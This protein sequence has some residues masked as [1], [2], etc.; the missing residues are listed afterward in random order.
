MPKNLAPTRVGPCPSLHYPPP[1]RNVHLW[2]I[3]F[4]LPAMNG[5]LPAELKFKDNT[6][7]SI[8]V[9]IGGWKG[10]NNGLET[11]YSV[12]LLLSSYASHLSHTLYEITYSPHLI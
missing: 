9:S 4:A 12:I 8:L 5:P 2:G 6:D 10:Q 1:L 3:F 7:Q 11:A